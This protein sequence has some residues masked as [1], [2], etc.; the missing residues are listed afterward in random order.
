[1]QEYSEA[2]KEMR[3]K[4]YRD[5]YAKNREKINERK[6]K[7]WEKKAKEAQNGKDK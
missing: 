6:R 3:R 7:Y 2:A 1:M 4:Y 5:Y